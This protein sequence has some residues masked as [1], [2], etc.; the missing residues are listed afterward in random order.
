MKNIYCKYCNKEHF[1]SP[2]K[3]RNKNI[4]AF[5]CGYN[6]NEIIKSKTFFW[7]RKNTSIEIKNLIEE[8][9]NDLENIGEIT[10]EYAISHNYNWKW[11]LFNTKQIL[12]DEYNMEV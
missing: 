6:Q 4:V 2:I 3:D 1:P 8:N 7:S 12:K 10:Y 11:F 5:S 9:I